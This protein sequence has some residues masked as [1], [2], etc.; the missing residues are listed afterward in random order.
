MEILSFP[1]NLPTYPHKWGALGAKFFLSPQSG[2][3]AGR[4]KGRIENETL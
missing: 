2:G 3:Q 4:R 1:D